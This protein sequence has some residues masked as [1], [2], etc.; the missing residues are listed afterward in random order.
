MG[1]YRKRPVVVEAIQF[2]GTNIEEI[3]ELLGWEWDGEGS[4]DRIIVETLEGDMTANVGTWIVRGV[5]GEAYPVQ[6]HIFKQT[7]EPVVEEGN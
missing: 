5:L 2:T 3:A 1:R 7:Y 4:S 6:E